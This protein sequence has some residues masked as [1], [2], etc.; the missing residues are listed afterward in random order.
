MKFLPQNTNI[1]F[2]GDAGMGENF[3]QIAPQLRT[4]DVYYTQPPVVG[5]HV[6]GEDEDG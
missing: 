6:I 3:G 1:V 5:F 4:F 2:V